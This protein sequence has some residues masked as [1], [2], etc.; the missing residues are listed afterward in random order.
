MGI[1]AFFSRVVADI[2]VL[3]SKNWINNP[4]KYQNKVLKN[5]IQKA[6]DTEFGKDYNFKNIHNYQ[7]FKEKVPVQDYEQIKGYIEK[8]Q[9][10]ESNILWPGLPLYFSKTS[11]T[12][13]GIKYIPITKESIHNQIKAARNSLLF[14]IN[15]LKNASLI[16]GKMIFLSGSPVLENRFK[17]P[18]GRLSGIVNHHIPRYLRKNQVPSYETNCIEDWETKIEQIVEET[19]N[20]DLRVI[21]GI[22]PWVQM[23]FDKIG[24]KTGKTIEE[25][26]PNFKLFIHGGVNYE[27]YR[28]QLIAKM[29]NAIDTL[30]T[31]PASEGFFAF[32]DTFYHGKFKQ[33]LPLNEKNDKPNGLLLLINHGIFYEFIPV[34]QIGAKDPLRLTLDEVVLN[35]NYAMVICTNAGLWAYLIGDTIKFV[36]KNPFRILVTGR[37]K[38]FISAFG[39]H[40]IVEEVENAIEEVSSLHQATIVEFTVAPQVSPLENSLPYHEWFIEFGVAPKNL[41]L[42][43]EDLD[44]TMQKKNHYYKDLIQGKILRPLKLISLKNNTF[45]EYMKR[46]GKLGGQNKVPHLSNHRKVVEELI[47]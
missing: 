36:S 25:V 32:Q 30:E 5:L 40:V 14:Y 34:A 27:P 2:V 10:G 9:N 20:Q 45:I 47:L 16:D 13:S 35:E 29:G 33:S 26:F 46:K 22:P 7:D 31:Y 21:S 43:V 37:I 15:S 8:I 39:E 12:T 17:I 23:Y 4:I 1:R 28:R 11:G 42:F 3:R 44:Q 19:Q 6:R 41:E 18:T 24:K 38:Q